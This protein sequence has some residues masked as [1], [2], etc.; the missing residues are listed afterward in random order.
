M[1][2]AK[3]EPQ[4]YVVVPN[5]DNIKSIKLQ[6]PTVIPSPPVTETEKLVSG[7]LY[8]CMDQALVNGRAFAKVCMQTLNTSDPL[9]INT[10]NKATLD[11]LGTKGENV[12]IEPPFFCDYGS[13]IHLGTATYLNFNCTFLD[14][15]PIRIGARCFLAPNVSIYT[16]THPI[17]PRA[18]SISEYSKP[19]TIG[20]DCWIGGCSIILPGVTIGDCSVVGAGSVVTK[21]VPPYTVVAGN[22]AKKIKDVP[23]LTS[24]AAIVPSK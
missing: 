5:P 11:L 8:N 1:A 14:G 24:D 22:P 4:A 21:D 19:V 12:W 10:R 20:D 9:D 23:R 2:A 15:A 7:E 17:E 3:A 6:V 18:R 13:N 16:A